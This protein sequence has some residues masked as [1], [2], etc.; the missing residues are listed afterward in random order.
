M[1]QWLT[2]A[3]LVNSKADAIERDP[4]KVSSEELLYNLSVVLLKL[5]DPF[6]G[7]PNKAALVDPGFVSSPKSHGGVYDLTGD[8]ALTRLGENVSHS[9]DVYNPKNSFIPLCF[10]FCSRALA[11]SI[12]PGMLH[13]DEI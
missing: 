7:N 2:D 1:I 5:C 3:L 12:V 4:T 8:N 10:F 9:G 13:Y 11:L 6:V